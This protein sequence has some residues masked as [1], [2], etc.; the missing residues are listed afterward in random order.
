MI[1][2]KR[3][4]PLKSCH[5]RECGR[6][7]LR[8]VIDMV[9]AKNRRVVVLTS[10]SWRNDRSSRSLGSSRLS[11]HLERGPINLGEMAP[12]TSRTEAAA[13]A[14]MSRDQ[15]K[16]AMRVG[17]VPKE[18]F[19]RQIESANPPTRAFLSHNA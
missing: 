5:C 1:K 19:E 16:T 18:D 10:R 4:V 3:K 17:N 13:D 7:G 12:P 14:G 11:P 6:R 15:F 9:D 8:C 2:R